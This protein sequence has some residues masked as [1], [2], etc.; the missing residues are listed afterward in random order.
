MAWSRGTTHPRD[1]QRLGV[2]DPDAINVVGHDTG[3]LQDLVADER[4]QTVLLSR[5][6]RPTHS[7]GPAPCNTTGYKPSRFKKDRLR[8]RSSSSLVKMAPP[9]LRARVHGDQLQ[10][11]TP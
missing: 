3:V 8:A 7:C 4:S 10:S 11:W 5:Q 6:Q 9:I 1:L 2:G